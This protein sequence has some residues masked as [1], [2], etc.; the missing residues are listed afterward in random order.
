VDAVAPA[1]IGFGLWLC[2][3]AWTNPNA[4]PIAKVKKALGSGSSAGALDVGAGGTN[5]AT[6]GGIGSA[7]A[8]NEAAGAPIVVG[9]G[10]RAD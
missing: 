1:L 8:D 10:N 3:E 9:G 4:A 2:Y 7:A 5:S 6:T